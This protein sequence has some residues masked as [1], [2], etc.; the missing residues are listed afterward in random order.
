MTCAT[1]AIPGVLVPDGSDIAA[2]SLSRPPPWNLIPFAV[3][4]PCCGRELNGLTTSRCPQCNL[5]IDW[6]TLVPLE[7]LACTQ[8]G[9]SLLGLRSDRCP[10]C[11]HRVVWAAVFADY[12]ERKRGLFEA[13]WRRAFA[14]SFIRT[15]WLAL[16]PRAFWSQVTLHDAPD[17]TGILLWIGML[18]GLLALLAP[19]CTGIV[20]WIWRGASFADLLRCI[21]DIAPCEAYLLSVLTYALGVLGALRLFGESIRRERI[22]PLHVI[23]IAAYTT[24]PLL[25]LVPLSYLILSVLGRFLHMRG[26]AHDGAVL[27]LVLVH[28]TWS[29]TQAGRRY[30][31][32]RHSAAVALAVQLMAL[33]GA[34]WFSEHLLG[35]ELIREYLRWA[36]APVLG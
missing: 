30:L 15:W 9:Y 7:A 2:D 33:F 31:Q 29:L 8:C 3:R 1:I 18:L 10:E 19:L 12:R 23:R 13:C 27:S 14:R 26:L 34:S 32:L 4:C 24:L 6:H 28:S 5:P 17:L 11:G 16:R 35:Q 22:H 20:D 36:L 21:A 25:P